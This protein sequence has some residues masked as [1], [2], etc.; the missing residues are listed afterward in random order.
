MLAKID[1][2]ELFY[3]VHGQ[4]RP[5]LLLHGGLGLDHTY[6]RPWLDALGSDVRLIF[7]DQRGNGRSTRP[8]SFEGLSHATWV[9]DAEALGA[10]LGHQRIILF[11]H[12]Y[13]G[14][15]AQEYAL[16]YGDH[17]AGLIL[18]ATAPALDYPE[19]IIANARSRGTPEQVQAVLSGLSRP[20]AF[21]G[22]DAW[23]QLWQTILPLYFKR[24]D[25][26][27]AAGLD[28]QTRYCGAAFSYSF[29]RCLPTFNVLERLGEIPTPTLVIAGRDDWIF[30]PA[31]AERIHAALPDSQLIIF[32]DSGHFPFIEERDKF[33]AVLANWLA[34][35]D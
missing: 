15:L 4:G 11:G 32:D 20:E 28:E 2:A 31:Q 17:L 22:D 19:V 7:Y 13:G 26:Q 9:A 30:P 8:T 6:F 10:S 3:T 24:Y 1:D 5:M 25:P 23:R 33:L 27:V 21:A 12:S 35:L 16:R 29:S 14:F 18:C 34:G